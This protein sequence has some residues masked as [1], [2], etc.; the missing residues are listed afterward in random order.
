VTIT[1]YPFENQDTSETDFSRLFKELQDSGVAGDVGSDAF[2]VTSDGSGMD[3]QIN[4]GFAMLRGHAI[5]S[6]AVETKTLAAAD[7]LY[8]RIDRVILRLDPV[9]N[10]ITIEVLQGDPAETPTAQ[11]LT[12]TETGVFELSLAEVTVPAG[13][14]NVAQS[15]INDNR[16]FMGMR[17]G[18]WKTSTRPTGTARRGRLGFNSD[19]A[20]WEFWNGTGWANM[21]VAKAVDSDKLG[22]VVAGDYL[23]K[24]GKAADADKL[25]GYDSS[26][27]AT[28]STIA[29]RT[30]D[31]RLLVGAP[32]GTTDATTKKYVDDG[33][34]GKLGLTAKAADADKL[35]G[36]DSSGFSRTTHTHTYTVFGSY[37]GDGMSGRT[38]ALPGRSVFVVVTD[39]ANT[40][41][42]YSGPA[43]NT[44]NRGL[45]GTSSGVI[46]TASNL[47]R[48][49][50]NTSGFQV[51]A[52]TSPDLNT[53]GQ[54]Y[55]YSAVL[56]AK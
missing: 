33:L 32:S 44:G 55:Q 16:T 3:V 8:P 5:H 48:P 49:T 50:L 21:V 9:A 45:S 28:A 34:A 22:G 20:T 31:G 43:G 54:T 38:I 27:T 6:S 23:L 24:T 19:T 17:L 56:E 41:T 51:S 26:A 37:V 52:G 11:S 42:G 13:S 40:I 4:P 12:Y 39:T 29:L 15:A 10:A 30:T 1:S 47:K 35:D 14:L 18:N 53:D 2:K 46:W 36:I 25:D 7:G